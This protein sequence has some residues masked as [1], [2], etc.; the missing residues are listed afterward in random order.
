MLK[1][2]FISV[3][4]KSWSG[5]KLLDPTIYFLSTGIQTQTLRKNVKSSNQSQKYNRRIV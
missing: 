5:G 1:N 4:L 2:G 3:T